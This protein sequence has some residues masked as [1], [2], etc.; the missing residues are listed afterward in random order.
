MWSTQNAQDR[1]EVILTAHYIGGAA[2]TLH[3]VLASND[4]TALGVANALANK[5]FEP[6]VD[7]PIITG[8]DCDILNVKNIIADKQAMSVF[9]DTRILAA[10]AVK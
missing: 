9:K 7:Y 1:F 10:Q 6:G 4:T 3:A 8:Q 2:K 5:G